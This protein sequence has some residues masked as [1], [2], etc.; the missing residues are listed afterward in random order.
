MDDMTKPLPQRRFGRTGIKFAYR[1]N[2]ELQNDISRTDM[3][4]I[5][6]EALSAD[7]G[8]ITITFG[9]NKIELEKLS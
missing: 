7:I 4:K 8:P 1:K 6:K 5:V 9:P 3:E 2:G